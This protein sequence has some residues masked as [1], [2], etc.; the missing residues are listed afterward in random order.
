MTLPITGGKVVAEGG[1][2]GFREEG[3]PLVHHPL[4]EC[5]EE[6]GYWPEVASF[7]FEV[8]VVEWHRSLSFSAVTCF[9][10][11]FFF[12]HLNLALGKCR[13][14]NKKKMN[15]IIQVNPPHPP[16]R[17]RNSCRL[18]KRLQQR[19]CLWWRR[20]V[21]LKNL[22]QELARSYSINAAILSNSCIPSA[23]HSDSSGEGATASLH[24][25][26]TFTQLHHSALLVPFWLAVF[27]P[28]EVLHVLRPL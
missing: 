28:S 23:S 9:F 17:C 21:S 27:I 6:I 1:G 5:R 12:T 11:C 7:I 3:N 18:M 20:L 26:L 10:K 2:G 16:P 14:Q 22:Q 19:L 4:S 15:I 25:Q 13:S 24:H 8:F